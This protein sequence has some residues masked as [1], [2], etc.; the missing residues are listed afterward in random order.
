MEL[1][2]F[3]FSSVN[4]LIKLHE[5]T[6]NQTDSSL[7]HRRKKPEEQMRVKQLLCRTFRPET[8]GSP[9]AECVVSSFMNLLLFTRRM[10]TGSSATWSLLLRLQVKES[11]RRHVNV[12]FRNIRF[13]PGTNDRD[14][15]YYLYLLY[16]IFFSHSFSSTRVS[17]KSLSLRNYE[18]LST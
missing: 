16:W 9:E 18:D 14:A 4:E 11:Q 7:I 8:S 17:M 5:S 12:T 2:W 10:F 13:P 6:R 1:T 3:I 15:Y